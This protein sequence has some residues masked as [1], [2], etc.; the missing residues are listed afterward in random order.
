LHGAPVFVFRPIVHNLAVV[1]SLEAKGAVFVRELGQIPPRAVVV[2]SA[3]GVS[4][5]VIRAPRRA[6]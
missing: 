6:A 2:F 1:R 5:D 4:P 3:H